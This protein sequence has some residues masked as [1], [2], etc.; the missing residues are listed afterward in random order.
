MKKNL[1]DELE[2]WIGTSEEANWNE[3]IAEHV[4]KAVIS[5][6]SL[7]DWILLNAVTLSRPNYWQQRLVASLGEDGSHN[8]VELL[9]CLLFSNFREVK[10]MATCEL[11]WAETP[12][13]EELKF[14][15]IEIVDEIVKVEG[16]DV[17]KNYS[18]IVDLL[19]R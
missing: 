5:S 19:N 17:Y 15:I 9:K 11:A 10:I 13:G 14:K 6:L 18:E 3:Y 1:F 7:D 16:E 12:I 2:Y 4:A 8:S